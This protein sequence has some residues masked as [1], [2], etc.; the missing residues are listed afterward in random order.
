MDASF[1]TLRIMWA[2]SR[3]IWSWLVMLDLDEPEPT[4]RESGAPSGLWRASGGGVSKVDRL[5]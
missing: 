5:R 1:F 4:G 3:L 2:S